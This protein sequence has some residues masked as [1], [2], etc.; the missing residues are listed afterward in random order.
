MHKF[1]WECRGRGL[2]SIIDYI[3]VRTEHMRRVKDRCKGGEGAE[4][5]SEHYLV[6]MKVQMRIVERSECIWNVRK[7]HIR[8]WKLKDAE[9]RR[10]YKNAMVRRSMELKH[11]IQ[12]G[13]VERGGR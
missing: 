13:S 11:A 5:Q 4:I 10:V 3:L 6:L 8:V 12:Q 1:T 7:G 2:R 9:V